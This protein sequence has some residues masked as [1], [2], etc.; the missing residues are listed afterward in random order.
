LFSRA[1]SVLAARSSGPSKY[2]VETIVACLSRLRSAI[3]RWARASVGTLSA[4]Q[5]QS[6]SFS[7]TPPAIAARIHL[8]LG[9]DPFFGCKSPTRVL[10]ARQRLKDQHLYRHTV[11]AN[12]I[13]RNR[14]DAANGQKVPRKDKIC[15]RAKSQ[16]LLRK[17]EASYATSLKGKVAIIAGI[18]LAGRGALK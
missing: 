15:P 13:R 16:G 7:A 3:Q 18:S 17:R 8:A 6:P 1:C 2:S 9:R 10:R 5:R 12:S 11:G 4:H 14:G